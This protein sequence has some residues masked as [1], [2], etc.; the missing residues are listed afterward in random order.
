MVQIPPEQQIWNAE[1]SYVPQKVQ[2]TQQRAGYEHPSQIGEPETQ[3]E[4]QD[5][6]HEEQ[7][8]HPPL[9]DNPD[10]HTMTHT[11]QDNTPDT[12]PFYS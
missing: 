2:S 10:N 8:D 6:E 4:R 5:R 11:P 7:T 3:T 1:T 12:P 9:I